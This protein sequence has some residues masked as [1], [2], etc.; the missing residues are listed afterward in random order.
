MFFKTMSE[1]YDTIVI[2]N[3]SMSEYCDIIAK[4]GTQGFAD[5]CGS[6]YKPEIMRY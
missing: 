2:R 3:I 1:K 4:L 6:S 5:L